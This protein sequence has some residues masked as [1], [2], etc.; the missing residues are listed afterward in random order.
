MTA[1]RVFPWEKNYTKDSNPVGDAPLPWDHPQTNVAP[2]PPAPAPAPEDPAAPRLP[3]PDAPMPPAAF[4]DSLSTELQTAARAAAQKALAVAQTAILNAVR[5]H[6]PDPTAPVDV[7][8]K[9]A[10]QAAARSRG[11]RALVIGLL[12]AVFWGILTAIGT[13]GHIELFDRAG[14]TSFAVLVG[15]AALN[16]VV[17]YVARMRIDPGLD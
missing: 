14:W 1:P 4:A 17:S 13:A 5:G 10:T 7:D 9:I 3:V 6:A 16:S 12:V 11:L 15:T 2:S 8:P